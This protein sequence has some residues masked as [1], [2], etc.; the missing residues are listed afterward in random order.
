MFA[1]KMA[2]I[3]AAL[4]ASSFSSVHAADALVLPAAKSFNPNISL[5]LQGLYKK[6]KA[7]GGE[8]ITG[9]WPAGH[10]HGT[11]A[12]EKNRGFLV[13]E[14]ELMLSANVDQH[15]KALV[16]VAYS[17]EEGAEVEEAW[18]Q[19]LSLGNGLTVKGGRFLS[20]IGYSNE[21]H[22]HI[23]DFADAPLMQRVLF[24]EHG[25]SQDG[26]QLK[27]LAPTETFIEFGLET[28]R[29]DKYPGTE[30]NKSGGNSGAVFVHLGGDIGEQHS[31]R[32]G[33]S[34]LSTQAT[35]RDVDVSDTSGEGVEIPFT[36]KSK[37]SI[38]DVVYKWSIA[39]GRSFKLQLETFRRK[40]TG[41]LTCA[42]AG[43]ATSLCA[44]EIS[45]TVART[46]KGGY[47][48]AV[49]QFD[50]AWRAGLRLDRLNS[51][52]TTYGSALAGVLPVVDYTP[53]RSSVMLD[54]SPS[55]FSRLRLQLAKDQ[56]Q[57]GLTDKQV[58]LQ[59]IM[60]LGAHG[61]HRF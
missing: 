5:T 60:S 16:N 33:V 56:A 3:A 21:Q 45:D 9:F 20:G 23:W 6:A 35:D 19:T 4:F 38:V 31:W 34:H 15:F 46:Q 14:S 58:T 10:A 57:Q 24:G 30:R 47:V 7:E 25:Y 59:Y 53:K 17:D 49:Y 18:F 26:V 28:G 1:K 32:A 48:Q 41:S 40:E 13:G 22:P 8:E 2:A 43:S 36:G 55:E 27:W 50:K 29:G 39:P 52:S 12:V 42:D 54:W 37:T 44:T 51:G 11:D 61:A